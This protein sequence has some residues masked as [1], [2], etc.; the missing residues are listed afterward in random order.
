MMGFSSGR[1]FWFT[2]IPQS[3]NR[4]SLTTESF[5]VQS[6]ST[7]AKEISDGTSGLVLLLFYSGTSLRCL[8]TTPTNTFN[9]QRGRSLVHEDVDLAAFQHRAAQ[10]ILI[11]HISCAGH[12]PHFVTSWATVELN[13]CRCVAS[14]VRIQ[15][16]RSV[17]GMDVEHGNSGVEMLVS[18]VRQTPHT[19]TNWRTVVLNLLLMSCVSFILLWV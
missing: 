14:F 5:C 7:L 8:C 4:R 16:S 15:V 2:S 9:Q 11:F 1:I 6:L 17:R 13:C 3:G 12:A 19:A 10:H 18:C